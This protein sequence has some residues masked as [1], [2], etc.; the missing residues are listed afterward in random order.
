MP[1]YLRVIEASVNKTHPGLGRTVA[2]LTCSVAARRCVLLVGPAG[3]GK[4]TALCALQN[5]FSPAMMPDSLTAASLKNIAETITG[6]NGV[7]L[8]DDMGKEAWMT[9]LRTLVT[10]TELVYGHF[11]TRNTVN[12]N[13]TIDGFTG[14]AVLNIQPNLMHTV[15]KS[16]EWDA[17]VQDKVLRFYHLHRPL[18]NNES[19]IELAQIRMPD[20]ATITVPKR[21]LSET[22]ALYNIGIT[23]W[24]RSRVN[25]HLTALLKASAALDGR[26]TATQRDV[27]VLADLLRPML[28]EKSIITRDQFEGGRVYRSGVQ[29]LLV[30]FASYGTFGLREL[31]DDYKLDPTQAHKAMMSLERWCEVISRTPLVYGPS[32]ELA[33]ILREVD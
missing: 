2:A 8:V 24:S 17:N 15:V 11:I 19:P 12:G 16:A 6:Y 14:G 18:K 25:V 4:S 3:T 23:Q 1:H 21:L 5:A 33:K 31:M 27:E 30:E 7:L 26:E 13:Y 32:A 28:A 29:H 10:I 22:S 20:L 9:R